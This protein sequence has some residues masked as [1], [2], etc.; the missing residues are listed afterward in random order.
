RRFRT[1]SW[2]SCGAI[3]AITEANVLAALTNCVAEH[4]GEYVRLVGVDPKAKRR[5]TEVMLQ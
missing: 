2:H 3:E 4:P 5:V 1:S